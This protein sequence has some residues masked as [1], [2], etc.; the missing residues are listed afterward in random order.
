MGEVW[1]LAHLCKDPPHPNPANKIED[2]DNYDNTRTK[3]LEHREEDICCLAIKATFF[4]SNRCVAMCVSVS[5]EKISQ[6]D[7]TV[8]FIMNHL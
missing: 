8:I 1:G 5:G 2:E 4:I 3:W 6:Y 7:V